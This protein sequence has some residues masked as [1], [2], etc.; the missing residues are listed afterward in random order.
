[1]PMPSAPLPLVYTPGNFPTVI[2]LDQ[3]HPRIASMVHEILVHQ[4]ILTKYDTGQ[5]QLNFKGREVKTELNKLA[6]NSAH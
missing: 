2:A 1:M 3:L 6:L 4:A 5:L